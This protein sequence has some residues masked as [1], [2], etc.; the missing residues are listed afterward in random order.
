[1]SHIFKANKNL[2]I[3]CLL[4]A[5]ITYTMYNQQFNNNLRKHK[6]RFTTLDNIFMIS[7]QNA[8]KIS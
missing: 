3:L 1:M 6:H 2:N 4:Y 8:S 5:Y 7:I